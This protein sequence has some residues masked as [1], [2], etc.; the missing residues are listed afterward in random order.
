MRRVKTELARWNIIPDDSAGIPLS[1]LPQGIFFKLLCDV[2]ETNCAP[3]E[4][5]AFLKHPFV[6]IGMKSGYFKRPLRILEDD[7]LRGPTPPEGLDGLKQHLQNK[8]NNLDLTKESS[9]EYRERLTSIF[10]TITHIEKVLS[11]LLYMPEKSKM[12]DF[13]SALISVINEITCKQT[14]DSTI[15]TAFWRDDTGRAMENMLLDFADNSELLG[16]IPTPALRGHLMEFMAKFLSANPMVS[17]KDYLYGVHQK[18]VCN[19]QIL[20]FLAA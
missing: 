6:T 8:I 1:D 11:P 13:I 4:L 2:L 20:L 18:H 9:I 14:D 7:L 16:Y 10:Q 19:K 3:I 15:I 12:Q 17:A 5:L